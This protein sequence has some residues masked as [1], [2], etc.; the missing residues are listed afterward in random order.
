[1][2]IRT[3]YCL[4][5]SNKPLFGQQG[6]FNAHFADIIKVC[7]VHRVRKLAAL[8]TMLRRLYILVRRK[9][10]KDNR[11]FI[12]IKNIFEPVLLKFVYRNRGGNIVSQNHIE[13]CTDKL[14]RSYAVKPCVRRQYLLR[15]CHSH[16][17]CSFI[18][19]Y[20][21]KTAPV[22]AE[23]TRREY[24]LSTPSFMFGSL[25]TNPSLR[26][27][28]SSSDTL[29]SSFPFGISIEIISPSLTNPIVP[30]SAKAS[31]AYPGRLSALHSG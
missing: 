5:R 6:V 28:S 30:P 27:A 10:V 29:S 20:A 1:M 17:Y 31:R 7:N 24:F 16:I 18:S 22:D 26:F 3:D 2:R 8:L 23:V 19:V 9:V 15:H 21:F 14:P 13:L 25:G 11:N 4:A 12:L